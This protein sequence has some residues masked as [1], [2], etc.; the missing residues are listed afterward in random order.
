MVLSGPGCGLSYDSEGLRFPMSAILEDSGL[1]RLHWEVLAIMYGM[2]IN[3]EA[4][5]PPASTLLL[6]FFP[7]LTPYSL[8]EST[9]FAR[10]GLASRCRMSLK[11]K[12]ER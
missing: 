1:G 3:V 6:I 8:V 4:V 12:T 11:W 2:P 5:V 7:A 10:S 9:R